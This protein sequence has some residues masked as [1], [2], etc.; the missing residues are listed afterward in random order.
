[1]EM[2]VNLRTLHNST[3]ISFRPNGTTKCQ[4]GTQAQFPLVSSDSS[5]EN[6][7]PTISSEGIDEITRTDR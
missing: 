4:Q 3:D 5:R 2:G 1:M 7:I 6:D